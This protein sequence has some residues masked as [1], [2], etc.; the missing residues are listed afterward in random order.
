MS[1]YIPLPQSPSLELYIV[2]CTVLSSESQ[3]FE[4]YTRY[5]DVSGKSKST[6][7]MMFS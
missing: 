4:L 1:I 3:A 6:F 7:R 2:R 5:G